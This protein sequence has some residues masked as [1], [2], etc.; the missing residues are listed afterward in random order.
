MALGIMES[1]AARFSRDILQRLDDR[2]SR[3]FDRRSPVTGNRQLREYVNRATGV[4]ASTLVPA[5]TVAPAVTGTATNGSTL[6]TTN[7][8]WTNTPT[9]TRKWLRDGVFIATQTGTTYVLVAADVGHK[10]SVEVTASK[11]GYPDTKAVSNQT[12][13]IT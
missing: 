4:A 7:G 6:T 13:T 2:K 9:F 8:T 11:S 10:I 1:A 5:N 12:A 3:G